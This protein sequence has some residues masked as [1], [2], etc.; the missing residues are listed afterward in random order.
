[1][2]TYEQFGNAPDSLAQNANLTI[3][4]VNEVMGAFPGQFKFT[5]GYRS[6]SYNA[7]IGGVAGSY[8]TKALAGDLSAY[9]KNYAAMKPGVISIL[10]KYGYELVD[11]S[12]SKNHF[13]IEPAPG[14]NPAKYDLS[15]SSNSSDNTTTI[16]LLLAAVFLLKG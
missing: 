3:H 5:S 10:A 8:H 12:N 14:T 1:M 2:I 6:P 11:E 4:I 13:H 9:N 15:D 7:S 16:I